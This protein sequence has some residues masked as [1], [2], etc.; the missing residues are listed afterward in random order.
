MASV[1]KPDRKEMK[2]LIKYL[3]HA[4]AVEIDMFF[5]DE[6]IGFLAD[7]D[8]HFQIF[9]MG[10]HWMDKHGIRITQATDHMSDRIERCHYEY[11]KEPMSE[12]PF[13]L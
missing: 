1:S 6:D 4:L 9:R 2:N 7:K 10:V 3:L 5:S 11:F 8:S 13:K 12:P